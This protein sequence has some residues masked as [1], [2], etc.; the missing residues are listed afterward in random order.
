MEKF[1]KKKHWDNLYKNKVFEGV[2][3]YQKTPKNSLEFLEKLKVSKNAKIID[4]GGGD[5]YFVDH[6][7]DRGFENITVLDISE[8]AIVR[9]KN[10]LG[11]KANKVKWIVEDVTIFEPSEYYDFWHDRAAFHFLTSDV[12]IK[13]YLSALD[14]GLNFGGYLLIGTFSEKGPLKCSG[15]DIKQYSDESLSKLF[16]EKYDQI[17]CLTDD[18]VTPTEKIQNFI[19][20]SF[21]RTN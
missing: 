1:D 5:S 16:N 14:K 3:W 11:E 17:N 19:F 20:C 12:E 13:K 15:I 8:N 10:R 18:H 7:L 6:L 4:I 21:Q 2:S 9:A